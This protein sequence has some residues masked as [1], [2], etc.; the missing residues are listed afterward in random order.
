MKVGYLV[1][2]FPT[3]SQTFVLDEIKG[4][5]NNNVE[6][7]AVSLIKAAAGSPAWRNLDRARVAIVDV[8]KVRFWKFGLVEKL[9]VAALELAAQ[10][11]LKPILQ[12]RSLG[13]L[14][15]RL[16]VIGL[17]RAIRVNRKLAGLDLLHCHF[18]PNGRYAAALKQAGAFDRPIVTTFH[19]YEL[20]SLLR[21]VKPGYYET[22]FK[23]GALFL[24]I[25]RHWVGKLVALGCDPARIVVHH[26]GI[27][28]PRNP[29]HDRSGG[30]P[31]LIATGRLIEK[32]GHTYTLRALALVKQRDPHLAFSLDIVGEGPQLARL[33]AEAVQLGLADRVTFHG[34]LPHGRTLELLNQ[35]SIFILPS[36]TATDGDVEGIPVAIMEAM[37]Q[38]LPVISTFHSGIPELVED[39]VSGLLVPE[40]D[41]EALAAAIEA[42][43]ST[44]QKWGEV[45]RAGRRKIESEFNGSALSRQLLE[46][47]KS[48]VTSPEPERSR[49]LE[50]A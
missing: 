44:P 40:R 38:G 36:V 14:N 42:M 15:D 32:K 16:T 29:F 12:D 4:H 3:L 21:V 7:V 41:V 5:L 20:S 50:K 37:A 49:V 35:A 10:P 17:A 8:F 33:Q 39:G 26:M 27:D 24:P 28:C 48:T 2:E 13:G 9:L 34:G 46:L 19:A 43:L 30:G 23:F 18:G 47:Y 31:R 25:S 45:G 11:R 6:V 22:L 1:T